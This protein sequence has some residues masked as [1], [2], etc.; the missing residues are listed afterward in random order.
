VNEPFIT[1]GNL[2]PGYDVQPVLLGVSLAVPRGSPTT[3][4]GANGSGRSTL[5]KTSVG[6][7]PTVSLAD[8]VFLGM[9]CGLAFLA[10]ELLRLNRSNARASVA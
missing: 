3:I 10:Q 8:V 2:P 7:Q 1:L 9:I 5:L 4:L 6:L